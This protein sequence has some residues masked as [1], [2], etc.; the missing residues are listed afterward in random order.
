MT[1]SVRLRLQH[2]DRNCREADDN[3]Q[4]NKSGKFIDYYHY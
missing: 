3:F 1:V 2:C 4:C